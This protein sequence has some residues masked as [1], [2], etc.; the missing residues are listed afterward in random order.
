MSK[1]PKRIYLVR[2]TET[3]DER[4]IR[5]ANAAQA[6]NHAAR[7]TFGVAVASQEQLVALLTGDTPAPVEDASAAEEVAA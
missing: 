5:A 6:R 4:L 7:E 3:G 1:A 2:N